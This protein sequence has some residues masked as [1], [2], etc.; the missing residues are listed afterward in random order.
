MGT[1]GQD[2]Y[3]ATL[4][5]IDTASF[6]FTRGVERLLNKRMV[7]SYG[8]RYIHLLPSRRSAGYAGRIAD[9][10]AYHYP[11]V[12]VFFDTVSIEPGEDFHA[13]VVV[14][15]WSSEV[16]LAIIGAAW[17]GGVDLAAVVDLTILTTSFALS[18]RWHCRC[19]QG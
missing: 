13:A 12:R 19:A 3:F 6:I 15:L 7:T 11:D 17:V 5:R 9:Y 10:F 4:P 8:R 2:R 1:L 18:Y 14:V 16:V